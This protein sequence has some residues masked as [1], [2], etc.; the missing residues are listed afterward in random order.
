CHYKR[1][2]DALARNIA[3]RDAELPVREFEKIIIIAADTEC[4]PARAV[5]IQS[6]DARQFLRKQALLNFSCDLDLA[7]DPFL[8]RRFLC[9]RLR[10]SRIVQRKSRLRSDRPQ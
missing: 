10:Q 7:V 5:I 1:S 8:L 3:D 6:R 9:D 2:S 4:R